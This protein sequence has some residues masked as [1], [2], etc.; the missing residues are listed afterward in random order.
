MRAFVGCPK[1]AP[2]GVVM[3]PGHLIPEP[4]PLGLGRPPSL[5]RS[6]LGSLDGGTPLSWPPCNLAAACHVFT[7]SHTEVPR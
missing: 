5:S 3:L 2:Q 1:Q 7:E 6:S 4:Q